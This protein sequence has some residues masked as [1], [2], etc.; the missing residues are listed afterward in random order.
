MFGV[1]LIIVT[2]GTMYS[3]I[4]GQGHNLS[5]VGTF[6]FCRVILGIGAGGDFPISARTYRTLESN[7]S[8]AYNNRF[9]FN[10]KLSSPNSR[11]QDTGEQC[12]QE[13]IPCSPL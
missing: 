8:P 6:I 3:A 1:E 12:W 5:F 7:N 2:I 10:I 13:D 4:S 9:S 11:Q